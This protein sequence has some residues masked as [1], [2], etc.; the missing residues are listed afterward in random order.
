MIA[1][2]CHR[3]E[4]ILISDHLSWSSAAGVFLPD[5]LPLPYTYEALDI[6]ARNI[7]R[8]QSAL[9]RSILIENPSVYL[10]FGDIELSEG[11]FLGEL[12]RRTGCGLLLDVN[13]VAVTAANLG[14][15]AEA[16]LGACLDACRMTPSERF[17]WR[18]TPS[19]ICP[20]AGNSE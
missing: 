19:A 6:F 17:T 5:L 10:A 16:R 3:V 2:L 9:R 1:G 8:V 18:V 15:S 7:D 12:V 13:N 11:A 4:P 14:E 20:V